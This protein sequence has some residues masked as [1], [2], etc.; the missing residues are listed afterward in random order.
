MSNEQKVSNKPRGLSALARTIQEHAW[1]LLG[2]KVLGYALALAALAAVGSGALARLAPG[3][4]AVSAVVPDA[5]AASASASA[6]APPP[7][8]DAGAPDAAPGDGGAPVSGGIAPD[9][10]VILNQATEADL[11]KL[12]G[13]GPARAKAILALRTKLGRFKRPEDLMR[14]KGIGRRMM[15]R[16][17]PMVR[18]D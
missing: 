9:G 4:R 11:R 3:A 5:L 6:E 16:L 18:V 1:A 13:I 15:A 10:K 17:R 2:L 14:V 7:I 12:P 8:A